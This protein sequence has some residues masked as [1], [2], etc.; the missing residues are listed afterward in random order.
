M[1]VKYCEYCKFYNIVDGTSY[2][3]RLGQSFE[4]QNSDK[5]SIVFTMFCIEIV[6]H[7]TFL[8]LILIQLSVKKNNFQYTE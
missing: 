7:F 2:I 8:L 5:V 1:N 3:P 4:T 6:E